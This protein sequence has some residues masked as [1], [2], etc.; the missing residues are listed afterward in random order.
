[1]GVT[2][3]AVSDR[4]MVT[5]ESTLDS[6]T[7]EALWELYQ[8]AFAPLEDRAAGR[9]FLSR[10]DFDSEVL[11]SRVVKYLARIPIG[12]IVGLCTLSADLDTVPWISPSFYRTRYPAHAARG[13]VLYCGIALVHPDAQRTRAF[14]DM[15]AAMAVD[16]AGVDGVLVADMCRYNV[17][18]VPVART[19]DVVMNRVWGSAQQVELDRQLYLAWEPTPRAPVS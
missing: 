1:M 11:D 10:S 3:T 9:Q 2:P 15:L 19:V 4:I 12:R 5:A 14:P 6:A 7:A 16:I 18:D 8:L 13:A 17:D